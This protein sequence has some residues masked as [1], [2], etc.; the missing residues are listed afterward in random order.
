MF[1]D[2]FERGDKA[3]QAK[4]EAKV[5]ALVGTRYTLDDIINLGD[6]PSD[7]PADKP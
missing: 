7:D 1:E 2:A 6:E 3:A 5:I 4:W